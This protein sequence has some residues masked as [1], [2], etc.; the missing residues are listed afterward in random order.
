MTTVS[1]LTSSYGRYLRR[2]LLL[3]RR[4]RTFFVDLRCLGLRGHPGARPPVHRRVTSFVRG[5]RLEAASHVETDGLAV[6][7]EILWTMQSIVDKVRGS[8]AHPYYS[9]ALN[10]ANAEPL[11]LRGAAMGRCAGGLS[12]ETSEEEN[13]SALV[14]GIP[15][16][17]I[18]SLP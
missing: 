1:Y 17:Y 9:G 10:P 11:K 3:I 5:I 8:A 4:C 6:L 18:G 16:V 13:R 2:C 15:Q 14:H 12:L 7:H